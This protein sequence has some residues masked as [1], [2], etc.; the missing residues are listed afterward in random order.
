MKT[1]NK[2]IIIVC[3]LFIFLIFASADNV[4]AQISSVKQNIG[5]SAISTGTASAATSGNK[6][7]ATASS[8][9]TS[10]AIQKKA[11]AAANNSVISDDEFTN[12]EFLT[13]E[14]LEKLLTDMGS[15]MAQ[16]YDGIKPAD[17]I[18]EV[19]KENNV[20]PLVILATLQKEQG[21][22]QTKKKITKS[23]LDW[24]MGVGVYDDNSHNQAYKGFKKQITGAAHTFRK[25]F[26]AGVSALASKVAK[27]KIN[28]GKDSITPANAAT[29]SLYAYTPHTAGAKLFTSIYKSYKSKLEKVRAAAPAATTTAISP[30][31]IT[32][33]AA[34]SGRI[35]E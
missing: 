2:K 30:A 15:P 28:Y 17:V 20:N 23:R 9:A 25:N 32:E 34:P 18:I 31:R 35:T 21:L 33:T 29:Y 13:K 6:A 1:S 10:K 26:D 11:A 19:A 22:V 14:E 7:P 5:K 12:S 4:F 27:M 3:T 16:E 8:S 24:A